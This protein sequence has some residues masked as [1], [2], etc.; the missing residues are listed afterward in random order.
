ME[1]SA[2]TCPQV[3]EVYGV[4]CH[5]RNLRHRHGDGDANSDGHTGDRPAEDMSPLP[6]RGQPAEAAPMSDVR[7]LGRDMHA[8]GADGG[9]DGDHDAP[10]RVGSSDAN[11]GDAI[12]LATV[13][14][15]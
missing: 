12:M 14:I 5:V 15:V 11:D 10:V 7:D 1:V 9:G 13:V 6:V 8:D 2:V 3:V 4:P